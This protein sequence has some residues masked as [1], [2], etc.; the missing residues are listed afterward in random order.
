MFITLFGQ[1]KIKVKI[2]RCNGYN[3]F[4]LLIPSS[5]VSC[6]LL[7]LSDIGTIDTSGFVHLLVQLLE[8]SLNDAS[9]CHKELLEVIETVIRRGMVYE[10]QCN[11]CWLLR[12]LS[13][14]IRILS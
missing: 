5:I 3:L 1:R 4:F 2:N 14:T 9:T 13:H 11:K 10:A 8:R 6:I 7:F 12:E